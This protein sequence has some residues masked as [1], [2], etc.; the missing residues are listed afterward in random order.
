MLEESKEK[1]YLEILAEERTNL[2]R[3]RTQMALVRTVLAIVVTLLAG[4]KIMAII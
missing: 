1:N 4:L 3:K 2:A